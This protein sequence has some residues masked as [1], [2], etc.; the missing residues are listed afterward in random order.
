MSEDARD[1]TQEQRTIERLKRRNDRYFRI[2]RKRGTQ[3]RRAWREIGGRKA[4]EEELKV[5]IINRHVALCELQEKFDKLQRDYR[6]LETEHK[7]TRAV[8]HEYTPYKGMAVPNSHATR[9]LV[10][11]KNRWRENAERDGALLREAN[12]ELHKAVSTLMDFG[13]YTIDVVQGIKQL[14]ADITEPE[15]KPRRPWWRRLRNTD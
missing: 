15:P 10:Q 2:I 14:V 6:G 13:V 5:E 7:A 4:Y 12:A 11:D 8:L 9:W 3:L 1:L